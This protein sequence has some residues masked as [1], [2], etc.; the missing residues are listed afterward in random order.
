[1][2]WLEDGRMNTKSDGEREGD[3]KFSPR[4]PEFLQERGGKRNRTVGS[5]N[6]GDDARGDFRGDV[7][8]LADDLAEGRGEE[9]DE[10]AM[11]E[12]GESHEREVRGMGNTG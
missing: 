12:R 9:E 1:M 7:G 8:D 11:K 6:G 3:R 10:I 2:R 5:R 4:G